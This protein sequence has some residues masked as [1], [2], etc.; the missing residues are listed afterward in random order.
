MGAISFVNTVPIYSDFTP[1]VDIELFYDVPARLNARILAGQLDVSPVSSACYLRNKD[2]LV[3]LEDLSVSSPGGVES[4]IFFSKK[5]L[6][7]EILDFPVI[8]VPDDSE[9]SVMLL[10][11]LLKEA[12]GQDLR[13]YFRIYGAA[14]Y[15][16]T[17]KETGNAL[18][19]GD[20]ALLVQE[21]G[22]SEGMHCYDLSSLW[23]ERTGLPFVFAVWVADSAWAERHPDELSGVNRELV[24]ARNRF[25]AE[26]SVFEAGLQLAQSRSALPRETLTRYYRQCLAYGLGEAEQASLALFENIIHSAEHWE[27]SRERQ[28]V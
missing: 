17:L 11:Y 7:S 12:T 13:S 23:K 6:G 14:D 25:F 1:P 10:A 19:I 8:S 21:A 15:Q 18:V 26:P 28:S 22:A 4:V 3:L 16:Q 2:K 9:T 24:A 5:P 20:N 27:S